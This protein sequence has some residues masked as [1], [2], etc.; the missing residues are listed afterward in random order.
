MSK[1]S[2]GV[3]DSFAKIF[4]LKQWKKNKNKWPSKKQWFSFFN[5]ISKTEK[6]IFFSFLFLAIVSSLLWWRLS[7]LE[8]TKIEPAEGGIIKEVIIG[9]PQSLNPL[10]SLLNDADRDVSEL[11]F[12]GLLK[13]TKDGKLIEDLAKEYKLSSD[14]KVYEFKLK[15]NLLW[16]DGE[17][18]TA[19]D[20]VFTIESIKNPEVQSPLRITWQDIKVEKADEQ[21]IKF[22]LKNPYFPFLENFTLK[23]LP[24][25]IFTDIEPQEIF[26]KPKEEIISSGPLKIKSIE[27]EKEDRIKKIIL[28][29][30]PNFHGKSLFLDEI[31]LIFT[32]DELELEELKTQ[33]TNLPNISP[34]DK[35]NLEE[36]FKTY[37]LSLPRYFALFLNQ[38]N[39]ILSQKEIRESLAL[40]TPREEIINQVLAGEGRIIEGPLLE[41]NKIGGEFKK[42]KFNLEE[43]KKKLDETGWKDGNKDGVREKV[44]KEGEKATTLELNLFTVDQ[45]ELKETAEI[46][47]KKWKEIG[48]KLNIH[49]VEGEKLRQ[50]YIAERKY[51]I[52]LFAQGL[53]M[54]ADPSSFWHSSQ[55]KYP[56]SN[57]SLYQN[58]DVD[59]ILK[60]SIAELD[61]EKRKKLLQSFQQKIAEDTPA[62]FL[63]SPNYLYAVDKKVKGIDGKYIIDP[64]KRFIGIENWYIEEKR[65]PKE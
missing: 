34:K 12:S 46:I 15:D 27:K 49:A 23:I 20:V 62:I 64:S 8:N 42:Y 51:D 31:E 9:Q 11:I 36:N 61:S 43:A 38:E 6:I 59:E 29:K 13:Y 39:K 47:Q 3:K 2:N 22:I 16:S 41:E 21:T 53:Y 19:E 37:S 60:K 18:I 5:I 48:V 33:A 56:G 32:K 28:D 4:Y 63:Y 65:V 58:T 14:G 17:K 24:S 1:F 26:L 25:H 50:D 45:A 44:I 57:L 52:L 54:I 35:N 55:K 10:F 40:V 30:N 7:I